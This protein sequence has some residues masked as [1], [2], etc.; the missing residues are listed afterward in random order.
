[1]RTMIGECLRQ[2]GII[3]EEDLQ[4]A[5]V[6]HRRSGERLG[7]VLIRLGF[8]TE[9]QIAEALAQQL[10]FEY[11]D[12][13]AHPPDPTAVVLIPKDVAL[14]RNCIAVAV[15]KNGLTVAMSDPLLFTLVQDLEFQTGHRIKQVVATRAE[16][17]D[18][19]HAWY[20]DHA[21]ARVTPGARGPREQTTP[22][23]GMLAP[24]GGTLAP[25][26]RPTS[27]STVREEDV[28]EQTSAAPAATAETAPIID[29]VDLVIK[30][31]LNSR[32]SDIHIE[33]TEGD[34][35]V[36]QRLDG[37]LK[38]TMDMPKWVHDGLVAR[39]KIMAGLD[40][41]E[42]R[43]PQD[44][45]IRA[46]SEDGEEVD[47]R[48]STLRTIFGEKIV[49]R[50]LDH[51]KGVPPL[52]ELGLSAASM[53][54][55]RYFLRHQ[56]GMILVV[57]PTGS[58]KTT[59]LSSA[60]ASIRSERTN[61]ITIE[62]PVEYQIPG[63]N[64]TQI[65]AKINLTFANALRSILRQD[66]DVVLVGEIRDQE[67][68]RIAM[69]AAQTGH[70]VLST[71]HTDD[72]PSCVTRLTDIGI[73]PYVTAS[74]LIGVIAQRLV[75]RLCM[76]CR[77]PYTPEPETL[78]AMRVSD[79]EAAMLTF[80]RA[81]GCE[82][83]HHTGYRGRVGIYEIMTV[84]DD[85]RR[86]IAQRGAEAQLREAALASGMISLGEDGL[87]KVKAGITTPQEL[88]RVV[89]E[90]RETRLLCPDCGTRVAP[91]FT[92]CP[93]CGRRVGGG[94]PHCRRPIQPEWKYCPYC[95]KNT[96]AAPGGRRR[97]SRD[98]ASRD[99]ASRDIASRRPVP[100]LPP[101]NI[102]EFK[103]GT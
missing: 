43:L 44:G 94:C 74:A 57:G 36:R 88:L 68:A 26:N 18:A 95:A 31:A 47:L 45:R 55:I 103:K 30:S 72:A 35:I 29:M 8:A 67:T 24:R 50:V 10:G 33:P 41:A 16:I 27:L 17:I 65:N 25:R 51:R 42:K 13:A 100:E 73:E 93:E 38:Q 82:K 64:Q 87:L 1:M 63:V 15:Q 85:L 46:A 56:H 98:I 77:R 99:I 22:R 66:P 21:L 91:D 37:L 70:L 92:A 20:P 79:A 14:K 101:G 54:H 28:F 9:R 102:A 23:S 61:I 49:L 53:E 81:D 71:L 7:A 4:A 39:I 76:D 5:L 90:V 69:Q 19:I 32:A 86:L 59:T 62:D 75:R 2:A 11:V 83:C 58:G 40:I 12:L 60:L 48:V 84:T 89:T 6:E 3:T 34:V 52:E 80:Y 97:A 78:R 96:D